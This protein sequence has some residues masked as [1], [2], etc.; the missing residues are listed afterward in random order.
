[1]R[2][3]EQAAAADPTCAMAYWGIAYA[4]GPNYNLVW[5]DFGWEGAQHVVAHCHA[6]TQQALA[7]VDGV[8][9]VERTLIGHWP[10]AIPPAD[11]PTRHTTKTPNMMA[12]TMPM[13]QPCARSTGPFLLISMWRR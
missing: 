5:E 6:A 3:F 10:S 8:T 7:L 2:C 1:M 12:G 13:P 4:A 9:P 11:S